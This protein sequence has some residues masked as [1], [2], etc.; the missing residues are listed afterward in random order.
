MY[1]GFMKPS[2][3]VV[4][5]PSGNHD[6]QTEEGRRESPSP[7]PPPAE[8]GRAFRDCPPGPANSQQYSPPLHVY[9]RRYTQC[10]SLDKK[11]RRRRQEPCPT[12]RGRRSEEEILF[13]L[14]PE[15]EEKGKK[16]PKVEASDSGSRKQEKVD[17]LTHIWRKLS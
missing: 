1:T 12:V 11:R 6:R 5:Y 2:P 17:F 14:T 8:T 7:P 9:T 13:L 3:V 15:E 4:Y 10:Y 16:F